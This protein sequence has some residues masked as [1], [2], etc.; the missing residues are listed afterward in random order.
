M[1]GRAGGLSTTPELASSNATL[2]TLRTKRSS[3]LKDAVTQAIVISTA[4]AGSTSRAP[5]QRILA[6]SSSR[7]RRAACAAWQGAP[8]IPRSLVAGVEAVGP[9]PHLRVP[10][11]HE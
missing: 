4:R 11:A 3:L 1:A 7:E 6:S 5:R 8:R 2:E 9:L 10:A